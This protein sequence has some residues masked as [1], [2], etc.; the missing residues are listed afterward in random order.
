[1]NCNCFEAQVEGLVSDPYS[2]FAKTYPD[3]IPHPL[4]HKKSSSFLANSPYQGRTTA[5]YPFALSATQLCGMLG[6]NLGVLSCLNV[7]A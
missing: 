4:R 5:N 1:M 7:A 6:L 3:K 2:D